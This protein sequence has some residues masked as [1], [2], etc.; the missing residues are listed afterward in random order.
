MLKVTRFCVQPY[1]R[2]SGR[3]EPGEA[4]RFHH[5]ESALRRA[6]GMRRRVAGVAVYRVTG[7]PVQDLW[8]KPQLIAREGEVPMCDAP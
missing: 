8:G 7:W 6:R 2:R 3:L 4:E 5:P 1:V